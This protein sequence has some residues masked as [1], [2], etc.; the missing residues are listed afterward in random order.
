MSNPAF[1]NMLRFV[2]GQ[3][4]KAQVEA[5]ASAPVSVPVSE[6]TKKHTH[7]QPDQAEIFSQ[8]RNVINPDSEAFNPVSRLG[9]QMMNEEGKQIN[10]WKTPLNVLGL[11]F[12]E[13]YLADGASKAETNA[14]KEMGLSPI[15]ARNQIG[16][17]QRVL[18]SKERQDV[19]PH[20][21]AH[22]ALQSLG[23][24]AS[25]AQEAV[26][27]QLMIN[28]GINVKENMEFLKD[29]FRMDDK[30]FVDWLKD[31]AKS[32]SEAASEKLKNR[33]GKK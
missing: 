15:S 19:I 13:D 24:R 12:H 21:I 28:D 32:F 1:V 4:S 8:L 30:A 22:K 31:A 17:D 25:N 5:Q 18:H 11:S 3:T 14:L 7:T 16:A 10:Y 33:K 23:F 20:E 2:L 26:V 6:E 9:A 27:R 29:T